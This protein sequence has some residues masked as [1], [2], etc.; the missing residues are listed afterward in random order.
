VPEPSKRSGRNHGE[1][2]VLVP[3]RPS[4]QLRDSRSDRH[5]DDARRALHHGLQLEAT[6]A[7]DDAITPAVM[8][9]TPS[10]IIRQATPTTAARD[11]P[12]RRSAAARLRPAAGWSRGPQAATRA[13]RRNASSH[14]LR[15]NRRATNARPNSERRS[16]VSFTGATGLEP[17]TSGVTGRRS[18]QLSYAPERIGIRSVAAGLESGGPCR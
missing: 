2:H 3:A 13:A 14:L 15:A 18:N 7:I 8:A 6:S 1:T 5:D 12:A 17:A 16:E 9:T 10:T 4:R 11:A